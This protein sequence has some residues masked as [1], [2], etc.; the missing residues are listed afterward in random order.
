MKGRLLIPFAGLCICVLAWTADLTGAAENGF[1]LEQ[2]HNADAKFIGDGIITSVDEGIRILD[3]KGCE[4]Q[5][6]DG[7]S[8][9]WLYVQEGDSGEWDVA[10]SNHANETH[11]LR[12]SSEYEMLEDQRVLATDTLAIDPILVRVDDG[13]LLTHTTIEGTINNPDPD[14]ENGVYTV[15]LYRSEDLDHWEYVTDVIRGDQNLE[16]GDIRYV[17]GTLYYFFEMENYD[18]GPSAICAMTSKDGGKTWSQVKELLPAVADNEMANCEPTDTG[19]R[20]YVSS[21]YAC[22]GES[23]Q[24]ASVYYADY[25]PELDPVQTYKRSRMPDNEAVRLYDVKETDGQIYFLFARNFLTDC[26]LLLR[27]IEEE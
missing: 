16:D 18:K 14:G 8:A 17:D 2:Y 13:W 7:L 27:K 24:G 11:I 21:D 10:Y 23:Y 1:T 5:S 26:D 9:S 22:V 25:T 6:Y 20:L 4:I 15:K 12:L 3:L 19:W